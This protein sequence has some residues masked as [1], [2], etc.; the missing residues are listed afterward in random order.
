MGKKA[1]KPI[2][3]NDGAQLVSSG[4]NVSNSKSKRME[5]NGAFREQVSKTPIG[6]GVS[7]RNSSGNRTKD[8]TTE[9]RMG[10]NAHGFS[11]EMDA[12]RLNTPR[13]LEGVKNR[14][15][16]VKA[17]GNAV[18]PQIPAQIGRIIM[19]IENGG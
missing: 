2:S 13:M 19:E 10:G 4:E 15:K 6:E 12:D 5:R 1:T 8:R 11:T 14:A 7:G 3:E 9:S 18:V 16:R 17:L